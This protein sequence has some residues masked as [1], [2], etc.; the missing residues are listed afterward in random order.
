MKETTALHQVLQP[1][2]EW[3][4]I[5]ETPDKEAILAHLTKVPRL[6]VE[7]NAAQVDVRGD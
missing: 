1:H 2:A 5:I 6:R 3:L 4:G 7:S